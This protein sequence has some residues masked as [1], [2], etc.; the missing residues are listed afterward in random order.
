MLAWANSSCVNLTTSQIIVYAGTN[1][2]SHTYG[3]DPSDVEFDNGDELG[4]SVHAY[5]P[6]IQIR[7]VG[8]RIM[9]EGEGNNHNIQ[10]NNEVVTA[11][12]SPANNEVVIA[13]N[14]SS[15]WDN[16]AVGDGHVAKAEIASPVFRTYYCNASSNESMYS[17]AF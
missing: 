11:Y 4:V 5:V 14:W 9:Y 2:G 16:Q 12:S 7:T 13:H 3:Q 8:V 6:G 10:S 1:S 15:S 17:C